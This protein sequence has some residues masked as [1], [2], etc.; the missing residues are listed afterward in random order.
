VISS[1][2]R[3]TYHYNAGIIEEAEASISTEDARE[4]PKLNGT[5]RVRRKAAK[6]TLPWD[7]AAG[8][9]DIVSLPQPQAE[10]IPATRKPRIEEQPGE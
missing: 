6:R 1:S 9:L 4:G 8:K 5:V 3:I 10:D 2:Y 7:L